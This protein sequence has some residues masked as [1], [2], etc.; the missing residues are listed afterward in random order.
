MH[1]EDLFEIEV[2][3]CNCD[4]GSVP[5]GKFNNL[6]EFI[7]NCNRSLDLSHSLPRFSHPVI[8]KSTFDK[9]LTLKDIAK[10][11]VRSLTDSYDDLEIPKTLKDEL[12]HILPHNHFK[13]ALNE[14]EEKTWTFLDRH[15][16]HFGFKS[17]TTGVTTLM[18][19][20]NLEIWKK[21]HFSTKK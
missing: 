9:V 11:R 12:T 2:N 5:F 10:S 21:N 13:I 7:Q 14:F 19:I 6:E 1:G 17:P 16:E 18:G 15:Y 20:A 4:G 3:D 8:R